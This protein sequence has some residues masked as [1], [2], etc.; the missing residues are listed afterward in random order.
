M[1]TGERLFP[2]PSGLSYSTWFCVERFSTA[3]QAHPVRLLTMVRRA[4]SS[5]QHYVCLAV[6]LS[7]KDRSLTVSTKEELLQTY[8]DESSE[9]ASF[10]EI[11]PCCARFRCG[12][13]IAEGQWHHLVLV[14]SKGMLK[15][16][17]ATLY[18][19]G[20]LISTVKA[21]YAILKSIA[22]VLLSSSG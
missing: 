3:P 4:T 11:L 21:S 2:P 6:V 18:L 16:S 20:Q 12:E 19:D 17:M 1:G 5:E 7:G 15:N 22:F 9:E 10:Y 13:L 8:S 14:M